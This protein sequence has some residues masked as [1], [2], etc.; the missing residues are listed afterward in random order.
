M[1]E[2]GEC[3][4]MRRISK[5]IPPAWFEK[6]KDDYVVSNGKNACYEDMD[7]TTRRRLR[8]YLAKEQGNI[9]C[10]CM[11]RINL[12]TSHIEHFKP[13]DKFPDAEMD[14]YNMFA[15]CMGQENE[16]QYTKWHCDQKKNNWYNHLMPDPTSSDYEKCVDYNLK[17][18]TVPFHSNRDGRYTV[19]KNIIENLGLNA[20]FLVRNRRNAIMKSELYDDAEYDNDDWFEYIRYYDN[21]HEGQYEEYCNAII[22]L[23]RSMI[24]NKKSIICASLMNLLR[25]MMMRKILLS[26]MV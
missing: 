20:P 5:I 13:R 24:K 23:M 15:S 26:I 25:K 11:R 9:C 19:E 12:E 2:N 1:H 16:A 10:Y 18:E 7:S 6:W 21:V 17:G 14:Y 8:E 4:K 22:M 3:R